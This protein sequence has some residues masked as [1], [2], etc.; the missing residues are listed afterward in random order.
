[1]RMQLKFSF[2][3]ISPL[4]SFW[5][6]KHNLKP[7]RG[8]MCLEMLG[9]RLMEHAQYAMRMVR[10]FSTRKQLLAAVG[11]RCKQPTATSRN[12]IGPPGFR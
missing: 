12:V 2:E 3:R 7:N 11:A 6:R 5:E 9:I 1:M 8:V 10:L 4:T